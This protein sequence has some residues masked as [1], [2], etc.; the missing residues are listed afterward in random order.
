MG[1]K[2]RAMSCSLRSSQ[3]G[4]QL[5]DRKAAVRQGCSSSP[6]CE[7]KGSLAERQ[8]EEKG[9]PCFSEDFRRAADTPVKHWRGGNSVREEL[10]N[11]LRR[12]LFHL[13]R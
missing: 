6:M 10:V 9:K 1:K 2:E 11:S 3:R 7:G 12:Q 13:S 8:K 4:G 5:D